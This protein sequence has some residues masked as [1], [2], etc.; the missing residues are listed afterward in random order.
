MAKHT[1]YKTFTTAERQKLIRHI[2]KETPLEQIAMM[3]NYS[4]ADVKTYA[5]MYLAQK[6]VDDSKFC[7][8]CDKTKL[9]DKFWKHNDKHAS[10]CADCSN[11]KRNDRYK[12]EPEFNARVK[13]YRNKN[14]IKRHKEKYIKVSDRTPEEQ[15]KVRAY[16]KLRR[17]KDS[18]KI[19]AERLKQA[20]LLTN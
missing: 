2:N 16:G 7:I 20:R 11:K 5:K 8:A 6:I 4:Y 15:E 3:Y 9:L 18:A 19:W 1:I 13:K 10:I 12:N 17:K 14:S